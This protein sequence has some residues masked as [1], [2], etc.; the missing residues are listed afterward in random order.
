[1]DERTESF[2]TYEPE[3]YEWD[4]EE[5]ADRPPRVLWG[6]I[7]ALGVLVL[8]AFWL[9]RQSA[10]SGDTSAAALADARAELALAQ[11]ENEDLEAQV[12]AG[13][14]EPTAAPEPE[15]TAEETAPATTGK[16]QTYIVKSGDT[17]AGIALEF[18]GDSS[19]ADVIAEANDIADPAEIR[20]GDKLIIP[21]EPAT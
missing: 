1:M 19:L 2:E 6:R 18:Y 15:P 20:T 13:L 4:Y 21:P 7:L 5:A 9:G 16:E 3:S 10:P 17:L 8:V 11:Q 14:A 12:T